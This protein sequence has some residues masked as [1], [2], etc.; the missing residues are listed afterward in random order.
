MR[1][2]ISILVEDKFGALARIVELFSSRGYNLES[3]C[4][5]ECEDSGAQRLTLVCRG[6]GHVIEH[7][8]KKLQ[9]II[10]VFKVEDFLDYESITCELLLLKVK[11]KEGERSDI[12]SLINA[13]KGD[14]IEMNGNS[15]SFKAVG[16]AAQLN[17]LMQVFRDYEILQLART[18]EAAIRR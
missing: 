10:Y 8:I 18:G 13:Y 2:V 6:D 11:I 17:G 5:G 14:I 3:V 7:I 16:S 15:V 12:L 1:H 4:S 9:Q